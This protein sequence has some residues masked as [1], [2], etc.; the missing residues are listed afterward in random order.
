MRMQEIKTLLE[1]AQGR[2][3]HGLPAADGLLSLEASRSSRLHLWTE[4]AHCTLTRQRKH[5]RRC[6]LSYQVSRS[7]HPA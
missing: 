7:S 5:E 3:V 1:Q 2:C 6:S 4:L